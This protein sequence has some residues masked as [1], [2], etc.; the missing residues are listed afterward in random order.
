VAALAATVERGRYGWR[1]HIWTPALP[2]L[3]GACSRG[4]TSVLQDVC[5]AARRPATV[6]A[7]FFAI[8]YHSF[9]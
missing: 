6:L 5:R 9:S 1:L 8:G 3:G 7:A 4:A 2:A